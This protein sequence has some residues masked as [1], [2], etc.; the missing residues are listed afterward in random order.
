[1]QRINQLAAFALALVVAGG[2]HSETE[3]QRRERQSAQTLVA[4]ENADGISD[5]LTGTISGVKSA[6]RH[7]TYPVHINQFAPA[8]TGQRH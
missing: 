2:V 7:H 4:D 6:T 5:G 8:I 3:A 1:M